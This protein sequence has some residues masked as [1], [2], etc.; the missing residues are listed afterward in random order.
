M[1]EL[2]N[3]I[4]EFEQFILEH[5]KSVNISEEIKGLEDKIETLDAEIIAEMV[6]IRNS[7]KK[8]DLQ[9]DKLL[10]NNLSDRTYSDNIPQ[11]LH[12]SDLFNSNA[13]VKLQKA[14]E[15]EKQSL[16]EQFVNGE[17]LKNLEEQQ[18]EAKN[19]LDG[20]KKYDKNS[21][22]KMPAD[23]KL[24]SYAKV[25]LH[26]YL[27]TKAAHLIAK[28]E[29]EKIKLIDEDT[30]NKRIS[31]IDEEIKNLISNEI[32]KVNLTI[33][34]YAEL[35]KI[36]P[37]HRLEQL[38]QEQ[39]QYKQQLSD[40]VAELKEEKKVLIEK[41]NIVSELESTYQK[42]SELKEKYTAT[43]ADIENIRATLSDEEN[44]QYFI[45]ERLKL[46]S[47]L[48][49]YGVEQKDDIFTDEMLET[50]N[51][52]E[53]ILES[54]PSAGNIFTAEDIK[55]FADEL[56]SDIITK[57][58]EIDSINLSASKDK[59]FLT[60]NGKKIRIYSDIDNELVKG[61]YVS[62]NSMLDAFSRFV[63][64]PE[65]KVYVVKSR[66]KIYDKSD[67]DIQSINKIIKKI[68]KIS[69]EKNSLGTKIYGKESGKI[70]RKGIASVPSLYDIGE[71]EVSYI[72]K[73][74][75]IQALTE[76]FE[77]KMT[78]IDKTFDSTINDFDDKMQKIKQNFSSFIN[79]NLRR[80]N[81]EEETHTK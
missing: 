25:K 44:K 17:K 18:E 13:N 50:G 12:T 75:F 68:G 45:E 14:I 55:D 54:I 20:Y 21:I 2:N 36:S 16:I 64:S 66:N 4:K 71:H 81:K 7:I 3:I 60:V 9:L 30:A 43:P 58:D 39:E 1:Q 11:I 26:S 74:E 31:E 53:K 51:D 5:S 41:I 29:A 69:L 52:N 61:D 78:L 32:V 8:M 37:D 42:V 79:N 73:V 76:V 62:Q 38:K 59:T 22:S 72:S 57:A 48:S 80:E 77:Q 49:K 70:T 27:A 47:I 15:E 33:N 23:I 46:D 65:K 24:V 63:N 56:Y 35:L 28:I 10:M 67:L 19:K 40:R 6:E 34:K